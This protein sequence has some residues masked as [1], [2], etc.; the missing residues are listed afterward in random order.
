DQV[1]AGMAHMLELELKPQERQALE[2]HGTQVA[3]AYD[4]YLQGRG[5]LQNYDKPENIDSAISV[6]HRALSL[7][8]N[9]ALA[10]AGLGEAYWKKY[11]SQKEASWVKAS[12]KA[13]ERAVA[14]DANLAPAHVCLGTLHNGTGQ[15]MDAVE[16]FQNA[17][18]TEPTS[19]AAYRGLASAYEHLGRPVEAERTYRQAID[20]RPHYWAS[21]SWLGAFYNH[22]ARYTEAAEMFR[23]VVALAPDSFRGYSNLGAIYVFLGRYDEAIATLERSVALRPTASAYSNLGTAYF[24]QR[25]YV[26]AAR[27]YEEALKLDG[28]NHT[29]WW[30]LGDAYYWIPEKRALAAEPYQ[31]AIA[32]ISKKLEVN[33]GDPE[34]LGIRALCHAMRQEKKPAM[35]DLAAALK[36]AP[37]D[38]E[39]SF[40]AALVHNQFGEA[41]KALDFLAKALVAGYAPNIVR[42]TPNFENLQSN[43]QFQTLLR[44]KQ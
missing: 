1:A 34:L 33:P 11:E 3:G 41:Q 13:C 42:D 6:F 24:H 10:H 22:G 35:A 14:L 25:R 40:R 8:P 27:T 16:H 43:P 7:D 37:N 31:K 23:Q 5:Y 15:Y 29:V 26:D 36:I 38:A 21:Y 39:L 32:L 17:L 12:Q 28:R 20:V 30:N 18:K 4:F 44:G 19:D 9:Y 2:T